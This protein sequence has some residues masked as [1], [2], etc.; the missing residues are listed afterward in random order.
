M[1]D[2]EVTTLLE[3]WQEGDREAGDRLMSRIYKELRELAGL[4]LAKE[5]RKSHLL[6]P[7][8]LVHEVYARMIERTAPAAVNRSHFLSLASRVVRQ[9]L[10]DYSRERASKK[11]GGDQRRITLLDNLAEVPEK[12][13][14]ALD[15]DA[16]LQRLEAIRPRAARV[17]ELRFFGGLTMDETA[18]VMELSPATVGRSWNFARAWLKSEL[19][20]K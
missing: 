19:A 14:D 20:D 18:E 2:E 1:V 8:E 11:R 5:R 9:V 6:Q 12:K 10:I 16:A 15:L 4:A 7:T 3:R 13:V 17:V